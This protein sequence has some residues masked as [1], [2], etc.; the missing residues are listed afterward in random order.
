MRIAKIIFAKKKE[1]KTNVE[2]LKALINN[3]NFREAS[4]MF[5]NGQTVESNHYFIIELHF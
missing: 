5:D 2:N 4:L 3:K 1:N